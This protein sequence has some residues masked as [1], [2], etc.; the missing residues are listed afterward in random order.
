[1]N[2]DVMLALQCMYHNLLKMHSFC[3][4]LHATLCPSVRIN[5]EIQVKHDLWSRLYEGQNKIG[6]AHLRHIGS[7]IHA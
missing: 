6:G 7:A 4:A 1:M 5:K 3:W 2:I